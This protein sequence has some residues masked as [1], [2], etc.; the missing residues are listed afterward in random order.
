MK[1]A[2][3]QV[4]DGLRVATEHIDHLQ[5]GLRSSIEDLREAAGLGRVVRGFDVTADGPGVVVGPG[6][7]FDH[8]RH[9]LATDE[10]KRLDVTFQAGQ[11]EQFLCARYERVENHEVE[12]KPT[13]VWDSVDLVLQPTLP[14]VTDD[15][16]PL[17]KL[18]RS[19]DGSSFRVVGLDEVPPVTVTETTSG[20][21]TSS[22]TESTT[23]TETGTTTETTAP[24]T[25]S[26]TETTTATETATESGTM[27]TVA[28]QARTPALRLQQGVSA[29]AAPDGQGMQALVAALRAGLAGQPADPRV[30]VGVAKIPVDFAPV[31]ITFDTS[32]SAEVRPTAAAGWQSTGTARGEATFAGGN[33][34]DQYGLSSGSARPLAPANGLGAEAHAPEL[35]V[36][37]VATLSLAPGVA[38]SD[39]GPVVDRVTLVVRVT[40][41]EEGLGVACELAWSG[42]VDENQVAALEAELIA[43]T[44]S[45]QIGWKAVGE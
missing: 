7:A 30:T 11:D 14:A 38:S 8:A 26:G 10:P 21:E 33:V 13:L 1:P 17:V 34:V 40:R 4:F 36:T 9:R 28:P 43:L 6:L 3:I 37:H 39:D 29:L 44:W 19:P 16:I 27:T 42:D 15:P 35:A 45:A 22:P 5:D 12:G 23:A 18:V 32:L 31:G 2:G 20:T 41:A 24:E 25:A